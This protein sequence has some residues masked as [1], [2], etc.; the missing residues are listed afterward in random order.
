MSD[1]NVATEPAPRPSRFWRNYIVAALLATLGWD[2]AAQYVNF[3]NLWPLFAYFLIATAFLAWVAVASARTMLGRAGAALLAIATV[4][5]FIIVGTPLIAAAMK[6]RPPP[7]PMFSN[8]F[9]D[10]ERTLLPVW[11]RPSRVRDV[12]DRWAWIDHDDNVIVLIDAGKHGSAR[13]RG[14]RGGMH[15]TPF[16]LTI[17]GM[18]KFTIVQRCRNRL[19][20]LRPSGARVDLSLPDGAA[21]AVEPRMAELET[22]VAAAIRSLLPEGQRPEFDAALAIGTASRPAP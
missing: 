14:S 10:H 21:R 8:Y 3:G 15:E 1:A 18:E 2:V 19:I 22:D 4:I 7:R 12:L 17:D 13:L 20:V 11:W 6:L 5:A 9:G 16:G